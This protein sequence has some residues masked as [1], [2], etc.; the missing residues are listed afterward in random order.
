MRSP[1]ENEPVR[2]FKSPNAKGPSIPAT[3]PK[4]LMSPTAVGA[5]ELPSFSVGIAQNTGRY[6]VEVLTSTNS[7]SV[8]AVELGFVIKSNNATAATSRGTIECHS[9][10]RVLSECQALICIATNVTK[11]GT[12]PN[13]PI[14]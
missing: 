14:R 8:I 11:Y 3:L 4:P 13:T 10:S 2:V 1:I 12:I 9:R 6:A 5:T 7:P